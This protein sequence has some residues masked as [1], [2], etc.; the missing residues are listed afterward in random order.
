MLAAVLSVLA[1]L[2]LFHV[3]L[4][5]VV[6]CHVVGSFFLMLLTVDTLSEVL[7]AESLKSF[8]VV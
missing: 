7:H 6:G 8:S 3:T 1:Y 5:D 2:S 4:T